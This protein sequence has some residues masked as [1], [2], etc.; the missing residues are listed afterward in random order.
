MSA[1]RPNRPRIRREFTDLEKD[2][3]ADEA[4]AAI[5]AHFER[6]LTELT[7]DEPGVDGRF[8][9]IDAHRFSAAAYRNGR[10]VAA[11]TVSLGG[12]HRSTSIMYSNQ[13]N[14]PPNTCNEDL[15]IEHD[16]MSLYLKPLM[17]M[18]HGGPDRSKDKLSPEEAAEYLWGMFIDQVH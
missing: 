9:E 6:A 3:F 12:M 11:C 4:Y 13:E 10:K 15:H 7:G 18:F 1:T 14:V 5:K 2:A 8:K 17:G 16:A